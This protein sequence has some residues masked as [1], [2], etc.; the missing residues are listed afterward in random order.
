[1]NDILRNNEWIVLG[2][3]MFFLK[4]PVE[5]TGATRYTFITN[6]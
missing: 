6:P 5:C 2:Y 3:A 1:M 4:M